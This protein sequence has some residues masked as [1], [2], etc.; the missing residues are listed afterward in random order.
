M[1]VAQPLTANFMMTLAYRAREFAI[2]ELFRGNPG[3]VANKL[4]LD[5]VVPV[6]LAESKE[7]NL[8]LVC[9]IKYSEGE[10]FSRCLLFASLDYCTDQMRPGPSSWQPAIDSL[11]Y[12][13]VASLRQSVAERNATYLTLAH[14]DLAGLK[15]AMRRIWIP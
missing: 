10:D 15:P 1:T 7:Y 8:R 9:R 2:P 6:R 11:A 3:E 12:Q 14:G 13:M 4:A 5:Y